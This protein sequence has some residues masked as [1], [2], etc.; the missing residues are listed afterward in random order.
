MWIRN[1]S[2]TLVVIA[3]VG[4]AASRGWEVDAPA[5]GLTDPV[6]AR[7]KA[8]KTDVR[9]DAASKIRLAGKSV[10]RQALP[11]LIDRLANDKDGQVRLA[12]LDTLI[13]L[14]PDAAPAVPA[15]L[16]TLRTDVGGRGEEASHQDYR[17]ALALA[18]IGKPA[19]EGLV[20]LLKHKKESVR[21]E[22]VMSLGRIGPDA[23]PAVAEL[24]QM[25]GD[26]NERIG[27]EAVVA[28]GHIGTAAIDPL[29]AAS[30]ARDITVRRR[31]VDSLGHLSAPDEKA[32]QAVLKCASDPAPQVRAAAVKSLS[33]CGLEDDIL[34]PVVKENLR[35]GDEDVRLAVVNLLVQRRTLLRL[36]APD[37][38]SFL[39]AR[40]DG[41]AR[42]AAFLLGKSGPAAAPLL[43]AALDEKSSRIDEIA[44]ALAQIGRPLVDRLAEALKDPDPRVRRGAALAL[45]QIRPVAVGI[46]QKLMVGLG[47]P[48]REVK[49]AF[50]TAIGILGP[51]GRESVPAVRKLLQDSSAEVRGKAIE[52]LAHSAPR[53]DRLADDLTALVNDVDSGVQ[54]RAIDTLRSLGPLGKRALPDVIAKL[55][56]KQTEVRL[57]AALMIGSHGEA[58]AAAVPAA[59]DLARRSVARVTDDRRP[60][61]G[62]D[63]QGCPAGAGKA[64]R[65]R[66]RR[67]V[68]GSRGGRTEPGKLGAG[69]R[70][71]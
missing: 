2:W 69:R 16:E 24:I 71:G 36:M 70:S 40:E 17:S 1:L 57:A 41:S 58:A 53:D 61:T 48:D 20:G 18:G 59:L 32:K 38:Q 56:S 43:L 35:H 3:I 25:L 42:Y 7:L 10:Q 37:L 34:L 19:V 52:I 23:A 22:V 26:K 46:S 62:T 15:L 31:A 28:L 45:G 60:D 9:R 29:I 67:T 14:G 64:E 21:A 65:T 12:V 44:G 39:I 50:L 4:Q 51:R 47:D 5:A 6:I 33:G 66:E 30:A 54:R 68:R 63:G 27:A 13:S 55:E 8:E 49:A 11:L